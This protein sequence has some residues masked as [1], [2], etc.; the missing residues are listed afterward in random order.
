MIP[1]NQFTLKH[2]SDIDSVGEF[3]VGPLPT[4]YGNTLG[5]MLRRVLYSSIPGG[6][7]TAIKIEGV[8]HEYT[9]LS[10]IN[11]D[12]L[13]IL[14]SLKNVVIKTNTTEPI[15]LEID[16]AGKKGTTV[17]VTAGDIKTAGDVEIINKDYVIT[18][19]TDGQARF[20]AQLI[21]ERNVG[22][23]RPDEEHRKELG[24]LPVDADF[25][26]VELVNY[27]I[28][29]TRVGDETELDQLNLTIKTNGA[30]SPIDALDMSASI[31]NDMTVHLLENTKAMASGTVTKLV[32]PLKV[33]QKE[34]KED[35]KIMVADLNLSTRLT[36]ALLRSAYDDLSKLDG[37][38]QE[39]LANI[40]GMGE[41]SLDELLKVLK[42]Y[43]IN[44][45]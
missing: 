26:P 5:N 22:Y 30:M 34:E 9:T 32:N 13:T 29:P 2:I 28:T 10:G 36:N 4:G 37:F 8:S 7:I 12:V 16:V 25:S 39:E 38:T 14:L 17:D 45:I 35:K 33:Q 20:K 42:K 41:K 15:T 31:I 21:V 19:I 3:Q 18:K 11:N 43:E 24:M 1:L 40:R 6:A 23:K 44:I 27:T